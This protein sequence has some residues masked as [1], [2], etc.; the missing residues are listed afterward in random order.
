MKIKMKKTIYLCLMYMITTVTFGQTITNFVTPRVNH[1]VENQNK[2]WIA[3][4]NG[5]E[6]RSLVGNLE[7]TY[8]S[9]TGLAGNKV[10][11]LYVD[12]KKNMW[13]LTRE[14]GISKFDGSNWVN[15]SKQTSGT[16]KEIIAGWTFPTGLKIDTLA[17]IYSANNDTKYISF[18][19]A[20]GVIDL[21]GGNGTSAYRAYN[22]TNGNN[23]KGFQFEVNALGYSNLKLSVELYNP[24]GPKS[25]KAQYKISPAGMWLDINQSVMYPKHN[26]TAGVLREIPLPSDCDNKPDVIIR[27]VSTSDLTSADVPIQITSVL[28]FDNVLVSGEYQKASAGELSD[29]YASAVYEKAGVCWVGMNGGGLN[30]LDGSS[31]TLINFADTLNSNYVNDIVEDNLGNIWLATDGGIKK[32]NGSNWLTYVFSNRSEDNI[33]LKAMR[34]SKNN[35]WF[36]GLHGVKQFNGYSFI[37]HQIGDSIENDFVNNIAEDKYGNI[38]A[39]SLDGVSVY[40]QVWKHY[41]NDDLGSKLGTSCL[42]V[43]SATSIW[44]GSYGGGIS[45]YNVDK[46]KN[47][48]T[49][50][51]LISPEVTCVYSDT[52]GKIWVGTSSGVSILDITTNVR[53]IYNDMTQTIFPNPTKGIVNIIP[54]ELSTVKLLTIDKK[55]LQQ[56]RTNDQ[57]VKIDLS[58]YS[59]GVYLIV[60]ENKSLIKTQKIILN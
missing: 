54:G 22:W 5:V 8:N 6:V 58:N 53:D 35:I 48:S 40:N 42:L 12:S 31:W 27:I 13:A 37:N 41:S 52:S 50:E 45:Q 4:D 28:K 30:T 11:K 16:L 10:E 39:T 24:S 34:D 1:I 18:F 33:F 9:I 60:T 17:N 56:I 29:N 51:G 59:K 21:A 47:Y 7:T 32:Y 36:G 25:F 19:G 49:N 44:I 57:T 26:W 23:T 38:W 46:F 3:T 20:F 55:L 15:Y 14:D 2:I 43:D